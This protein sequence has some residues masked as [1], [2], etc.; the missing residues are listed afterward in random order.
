M[1]SE[2]Y[3]IVLDKY[4]KLKKMYDDKYKEK[5]KNIIKKH[6]NDYNLIRKEL[7]KYSPRCVNCDGIGG[8]LFIESENS[9]KALCSVADINARC[10]LHIELQKGSVINQEEW[11]Q[12]IT[13][14]LENDKINIISIKLDMLFGLIEE[15]I[16]IKSFNN[17]KED[18]KT[19]VKLMEE[20]NNF[21]Y[22]KNSVEI[23]KTSE[24]KQETTTERIEKKKFIKIKTTQL[25][26]NIKKYRETIEKYKSTNKKS[27][28]QDAL[29]AYKNDILPVINEIRKVKYELEYIEEING[30]PDKD[31]TI[32]LI[33]NIKNSIENQEILVKDYKVI[34]DKT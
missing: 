17:Y 1:A 33:R 32:W 21:N 8:S 5:K 11:F 7:S 30:D 23:E 22:E 25:K 14:D 16:A 13:N 31:P 18:Y 4:Y 3:L 24:S 15:D 26:N 28:L 19:N 29:H 10:N 34:S 9:I 12:E 27:F 6:K 20:W 2:N